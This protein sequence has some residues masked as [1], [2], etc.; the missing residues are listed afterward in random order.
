MQHALLVPG[1][2]LGLDGGFL[3]LSAIVLVRHDGGSP[4]LFDCGHHV[5]L[6]P[7]LAAL[8]AH[9]IDPG[10]IGTLVLSHL[11]FDHATNLDHFPNAQVV[12]SGDELSYAAAPHADDHWGAS[13]ILERLRRRDVRVVDGGEDIVPGLSVL[14]TPGHTPGHVALRYW[15]ADGARVTL[16]ADALKT[17]RE[18]TSGLPDMEFDPDRRGA[19]SLRRILADSD[20]IVPGHHP[21]LRRTESGFTWDA[22]SRLTL[23]TR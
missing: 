19:D 2:S 6:G 3:G 7:L 21:E 22:P 5:T 20:V 9:A 1:Q 12:V 13:A 14:R 10:E 16:A 23:V 8:K 4:I 18:A 17:L 11:H 15:R